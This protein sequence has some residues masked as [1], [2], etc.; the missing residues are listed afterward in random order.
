MSTVNIGC[1][2]PNGIM[3]AAM[4]GS[5]EVEHRINGW[6]QNL[7]QGA[8]HGLTTDVPEALW[9]AWK[10]AFK[11]SSLLKG[12]FI[13]AHKQE[14]AVKAEA[15]EKKANKSGQEQMPQVKAE[16]DTEGKLG[17]VS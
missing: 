3:M 17:K 6:N 9:D 15:T 7:I 2:L 10:E 13:F 4:V 1:K 14:K 11:E 8:D 16:A 5:A 12:G